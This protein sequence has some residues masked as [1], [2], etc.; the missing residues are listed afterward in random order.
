MKSSYEH[1]N[2]FV[3]AVG[4]PEDSDSGLDRTHESIKSM[5]SAAAKR[6]TTPTPTHNPTHHPKPDH[7]HHPAAHHSNGQAAPRVATQ[8]PEAPNSSQD[9]GRD[10]PA[11]LTREHSRQ[12]SFLFA[13]TGKTDKGKLVGEG[14]GGD[15]ATHLP[16]GA[17]HHTSGRRQLLDGGAR[18]G[19]RLETMAE[20]CGDYA[21]YTLSSGDQYRRPS[22]NGVVV[23]DPPGGQLPMPPNLARYPD[24]QRKDSFTKR[25]GSKEKGGVDVVRYQVDPGRAAGRTPP[26]FNGYQSQGEGGFS[27]Q[28]GEKVGHGKP[29][30]HHGRQRSLSSGREEEGGGVV[31]VSSG[32]QHV[33]VKPKPTGHGNNYDT[34]DGAHTALQSGLATLPRHK[35]QGHGSDNPAHPQQRPPAGPAH[36]ELAQLT[37]KTNLQCRPVD[38]PLPPGTPPPEYHPVPDPHETHSRQASVTSQASS[39][40]SSAS[41]GHIDQ[42]APPGKKPDG[43]EKAKK[44]VKKEKKSEKDPSKKSEKKKSKS[45][46]ALRKSDSEGDLL[47]ADR[48]GRSGQASGQASGQQGVG[49]YID[50][51]MVESILKHQGVHRQNSSCSN[52]SV[53]SVNSVSSIESDSIMGKLLA[54]KAAQAGGSGGLTVDI[55][56]DNMSL[57]SQKDSGYGSSDRNSSSSTGSGTIDPYSQYFISKSMVIPRSVNTQHVSCVGF[58]F[59]FSLTVFCFLFSDL[60]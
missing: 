8:A 41:M 30:V 33:V 43:G 22:L 37:R 6:S 1:F 42:A 36:Q 58:F 57:G 40:K 59:F 21:D 11:R 17:A 31:D 60:I 50:R 46:S 26:D 13:V 10:S 24:A 34:L 45:D 49:Q 28:R 12:P 19:G 18:A 44:K 55:P 53:N 29:P 32:S 54:S 23:G 5:A 39:M 51:R 25:V 2:V 16:G 9:A 15:G 4:V 27:P 35:G 47:A 7:H 48:P 52:N 20:D 56:F 14:G 38:P 3:V